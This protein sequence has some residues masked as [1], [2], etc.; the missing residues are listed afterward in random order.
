MDFEF[1]Q[2]LNL[3]KYLLN[4]GFGTYKSDELE[5]TSY[6]VNLN[7]AIRLF[8]EYPHLKKIIFHAN[9]QNF[10]VSTEQRGQLIKLIDAGKIEINHISRNELCIHSKLYRFKKGN[11]FVIGAIASSNFSENSNLN[12]ESMFISQNPQFFGDIASGVAEK[13]ERYEVKE[14]KTLPETLLQTIG[15]DQAIEK[16]LLEGLW[17]HQQAIMEWLAHRQ[18]AI[19][20]IPPGCGKTRIATRYIQHLCKQNR[21]TTVIVLV[22]TIT[23]INQWRE[24]LKNEGIDAFEVDTS[25]SNLGQYFAD[26]SGKV[27]ITLYSRFFDTYKTI[28]QKIRL[29]K[30][31]LLTVFD[32]SHNLYSNLDV[33]EHYYN[34]ISGANS[35]FENGYFLSLSAT[36]DSFFQENVDR[37]IN[38]N[39]GDQNRFSISIPS[40]YSYW[41][42]LNK[43]PCLKPIVYHPLFYHLTPSEMEKFRELSRYVGIESHTVNLKGDDS[44]GAAIKRARYVRG[45]EGGFK[46]LKNYIQTN[47]DS[48]NH[49]NTIIFVPTHAFAEELRSF[50]VNTKGWNPK[51]SAYVYDS[52]KSDF[53]LEHALEQFKNNLGFCLI[54]EIMLSE[55]F[56]IPIISRVI[57]HGSHKSQRD[58]V[59]KIGRAIRYDPKNIDTFAEVIDLIF[60]DNNKQVLPIEEERFETLKSISK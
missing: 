2:G 4:L 20:N 43:T 49:G 51:S 18:K 13:L 21:R 19:V 50:L 14:R 32:E 25:M 6:N 22:P 7:L 28:L 15:S 37:F 26:P 38:L 36:I 40:F 56:D 9:T 58:W 24:V 52:Q 23:L 59:Q 31:D 11:N 12:F 45:L 41:N 29:F 3:L 53:Y 48:F 30:P 10:S 46:T 57:I 16:H 44:F 27:I 8:S 42:N 39:G 34:Q 35:P 17:V 60:C 54:S 47:I 5:C 55:G 33:L 1:K